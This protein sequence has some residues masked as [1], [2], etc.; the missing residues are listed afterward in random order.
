M[1]EE[2]DDIEQ[3]IW[4]IVRLV[5]LR[6]RESGWERSSN[7]AGYW[8]R[9][10]L[11]LLKAEGERR[12]FFICA[13]GCAGDKAHGEW[14]YDH[15]WLDKDAKS[16][17]VIDMPLALESEWATN[18]SEHTYDFQKLLVCRA[19]HR[20]MVFYSPDQVRKTFDAFINQI[21][22]YRGT[23][24]GDRYLLIGV[25]RDDLWKRLLYVVP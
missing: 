12:E 10:L 3:A 14:L 22:D 19:R 23:R 15:V 9:A 18:R 25:D 21:I 16:G 8:S 2:L 11:A 1:T 6:A 5:K 7:W 4:S 20:V 24:P 13:N 17:H